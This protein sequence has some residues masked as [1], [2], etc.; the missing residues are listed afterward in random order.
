MKREK[1]AEQRSRKKHTLS[2]LQGANYKSTTRV[3]ILVFS[4]PA[5]QP[6]GCS[7][8]EIKPFNSFGSGR[9]AALAAPLEQNTKRSSY[10]MLLKE[11]EE[12]EEEVS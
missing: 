8:S 7:C 3:I 1:E 4:Q 11:E 6:I 2:Q 10:T 12:E 5:S 9:W